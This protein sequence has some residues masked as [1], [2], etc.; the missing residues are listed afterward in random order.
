MRDDGAMSE[1][2]I[3]V[4]CGA[5]PGLT[6][7]FTDIAY[8]VGDG[9]ARRG[10][11]VVFGGAREGL[12][13]ALANGVIDAGGDVVGVFPRELEGRDLLHPRVERMIQVGSLSERKHVMFEMAAAF[14]AL[15]GGYGTMDE[16]FEVLTTRQIGEHDKPIA[17]LNVSGFYDGLVAYLDRA[18]A[19]GIL[20]PIYRPL[21]ATPRT[22][23]ELFLWAERA[24]TTTS[25][26]RLVAAKALP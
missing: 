20:K 6:P 7:F 19:D 3:N 8:A 14:L 24:L 17:L 11:P 12:M 23:D 10:L 1:R 9:F 21:L 4:F 2:R 25:S 15:P 22:L 26:R 13:G 16:L 5:S 18:A